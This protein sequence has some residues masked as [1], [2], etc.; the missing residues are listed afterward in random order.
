MRTL[1]K[2]L[3]VILLC[4]IF[5][6]GCNNGNA[7][8]STK[9]ESSIS[10]STASASSASEPDNTCS[11]KT[12]S[13]L[14]IT[15]PTHYTGFLNETFGITSGPNGE[16]H[17]TN[18]GGKTWPAGNNSSMC[19][20]G[21]DIVNENIAWNCGNGANVRVTVDGGK[22]WKEAS[23]FGDFEPDHCRF[24]SFL[25]D[26]TGWIASPTR[27]AST[28]DGGKNWHEMN[29]PQGVTQISSIYL[30]TANDGYL[31]D[32]NGILYITGDSGKTWSSQDL[33]FGKLD[34]KDGRK[35]N[36]PNSAICF[37]SLST[38][39]IVINTKDTNGWKTC[40]LNTADSGKTWTQEQ[41]PLS[42]TYNKMLKVYL[43]KDGKLLTLA[44][45]DNNTI[46]L[47]STA[48]N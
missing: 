15:H 24:I 27:L 37:N 16:V 31:L 34:L 22:T 41:L 44:N 3:S 20:F 6:T 45:I 28:N 30:R 5:F 26:K 21:L 35:I 17:Y 10:H 39:I 13:E 11:W 29:L 40:V 48:P 14:Q 25:D 8:E 46:I 36:V 38:G 7:T 42:D 2:L 9:K 19:R 43:S 12:L 47:K 4:T 33:G 32:S 1:G 18:D 23:D